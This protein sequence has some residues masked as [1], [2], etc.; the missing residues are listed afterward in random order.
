MQVSDITFLAIFIATIALV[1]ALI[2]A[3]RMPMLL[4]SLPSVLIWS[5]ATFAYAGLPL[6]YFKMDPYRSQHVTDQQTVLLVLIYAS[7]AWI[8][9]AIGYLIFVKTVKKIPVPIQS[10]A[11]CFSKGQFYYCAFLFA[12]ALAAFA[13]YIAESP[14]LAIFASLHKNYE[15]QA[16]LRSQ[17]TNALFLNRF[18]WE[19]LLYGD[20]LSFLCFML[21][22]LALVRKQALVWVFWLLTFL[23]CLAASLVAAQ[24]ALLLQLLVALFLT[25]LLTRRQGR[26]NL[27]AVV[28]LACVAGLA[29]TGVL[30]LLANDSQSMLVAV[31]SL[32]S[33][34][35][36]GSVTPAYFYVKMFP[37]VHAFLHGAS[38]S[39]LMGLLPFEQFNLTHEVHVFMAPQY[40]ERGIVG[41]AP[42]AF[43]GEAYAN[44]GSIG[45]FFVAVLVGFCVCLLQALMDRLPASPTTVG[46]LAWLIVHVQFLSITSFSNYLFDQHVVVVGLAALGCALAGGR[47]RASDSSQ[48]CASWHS[49]RA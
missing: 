8:G 9:L 40:L 12:L 39:N 30:T 16:V 27:G 28:I 34:I 33:R 2:R 14:Q 45:P 4:V 11:D 49:S 22:S 6:L 1:T 13:F 21:F 23:L 41:S 29:L 35:I 10:V 36:T 42:T 20:V 5:Y 17:M 44:F 37:D 7:L 32:V 18:N 24:R 38:L 19:Q 31:T 3:S 46:L 48:T 15:A 47:N 43:W 25:G 26:F